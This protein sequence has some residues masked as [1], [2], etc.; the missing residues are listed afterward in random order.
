[1]KIELQLSNDA[2]VL[3]NKVL[4]KVYELPV[5]NVEK[6]NVYRSIAFDLADKF[7]KRVKKLIKNANLFEKRTNKLSIKYHEAWALQQ[8]LLD[9]EIELQN[10]YQITLRQGIIDKLNPKLI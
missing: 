9:A 1:M 5:S 6:E 2:L 7:D 8:I 4:Q 3:A 10:P